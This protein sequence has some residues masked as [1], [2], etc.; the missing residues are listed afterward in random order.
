MP[1]EK[2]FTYWIMANYGVAMVIYAYKGDWGRAY[3]WF[4]AIQIMAV[5][6][7]MVH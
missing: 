6:M 4:A 1:I 5:A 2:I 7:F 3:Y